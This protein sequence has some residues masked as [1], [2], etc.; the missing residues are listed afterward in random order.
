MARKRANAEYE[1]LSDSNIEKVIGLLSAEKPITKKAACEILCISY[2]TTRL[3]SIIN[4]YKEKKDH[5]RQQREKK[6]YKAASKEEIDLIV[7]SYLEGEPVTKIANTIYRSDN[8]V[9]NILDRVSCP[10]RIQGADYWNPEMIPEAAMRDSFTV[11]ERVW[12]ARYNSMAIIKALVPAQPDVYRVWLDAEEWQQ[13]AYQPYWELASLDH[14]RQQ[15]I[16]L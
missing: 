10:K 13:F 11:G 6:R 5:E 14:L 12:S 15:G 3:D 8:F 16:T 4:H 1:N 7:T 2:N 9:K